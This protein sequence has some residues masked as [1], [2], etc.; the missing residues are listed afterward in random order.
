VQVGLFGTAAV[1]SS[2]QGLCQAAVEPRRR[3]TWEQPLIP[4]LVIYPGGYLSG[5]PQFLADYAAQR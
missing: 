4:L 1:V 2:A 3:P 5:A